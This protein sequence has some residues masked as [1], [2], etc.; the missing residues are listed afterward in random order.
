MPRRKTY[1]LLAKDTDFYALL[2]DELR[3]M[4]P[5]LVNEYDMESIEISMKKKTKPQ[6]LDI[7]KAI[8]NLKRN[9]PTY[10]NEVG[11]FYDEPFVH[12][13]DIARFLGISRPTLDQWIRNGFI[14]AV[15]SKILRKEYI[16]PPEEIL[17][18]LL[19]IKNQNNY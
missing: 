7:D 2:V 9:L 4:N 15:Q 8:E 10:R 16:Y 19:Q 12:K 14:K 11:V 3:L 1:K 6:I 18:Q 17:N 5:E 13:N